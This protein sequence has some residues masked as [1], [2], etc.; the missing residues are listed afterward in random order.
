MD[1][2]I[3]LGI[4]HIGELIF[5]NVNTPTLIKC[6]L[7]SETWKILA[8][9]VFIKRIKRLNRKTFEALFWQARKN[10]RKYV[11]QLLI[12]THPNIHPRDANGLTAFMHLCVEGKKEIVQLLFGHLDPN[13]DLNAKHNGR[14]AFMI[15]CCNGN[16]YVVQLLLD[17]STPKVDLNAKDNGGLTAFM[18]ACTFVCKDVVQLLLNN[19]GRIDLNAR[20]NTG[21][22]ALMIACRNGS[23]DIVQLFLNHSERIELNAR[24][25]DGGTAFMLACY[26]G[27]IE[28][29]KLCLDYSEVL[30]VNVPKT[31]QLTQP[32]K[33]LF[34]L[35]KVRN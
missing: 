15:A 12:E 25:N 22:T 8:R 23:K 1:S 2:I 11:I 7:V 27:Q 18:W 13:I 35:K 31:N 29:V 9:K 3:N 10:G 28:V 20:S 26:N 24:D 32:I 17:H 4:P 33:D 5:E 34:L 14:T 30:Y 16:K 6:L 19:S 21:R